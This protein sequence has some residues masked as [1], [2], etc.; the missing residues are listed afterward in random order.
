MSLNYIELFAGCGGMSLGLDA[1]GFKL[2]FANEISP[3]AGETFS[4]NILGENL[5]D[6]KNWGKTLWIRSKYEKGNIKRFSEDPR[7]YHK[8]KKREFYEE[9]E[10]FI[11]DPGIN[12]KIRQVNTVFYRGFVFGLTG[13]GCYK[14]CIIVYRPL[15]G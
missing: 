6:S 3:M 2:H 7:Y 12:T 8:G 15:V 13:S 14:I 9:K 10:L 1:S 4:F 11:T 5:R